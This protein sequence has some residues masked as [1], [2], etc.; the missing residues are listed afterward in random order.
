MNKLLFSIERKGRK[1]GVSSA[2]DIM[3]KVLKWFVIVYIGFLFFGLG[4]GLNPMVEEMFPG[5]NIVAVVSRYIIFYFSAEL[6]FRFFLQKLPHGNIRPLLIQNITRSKIVK[7]FLTSS[8][9]S[10]F[11]F[12]QLIFFVTFSVASIFFLKGNYEVIA[13][14]FSMYAICLGLHYVF[15]LMESYNTVFY[16]VIVVIG[17]LGVVQYY[18]LYDLGVYLEPIFY[19]P[20]KNPAALVL[21][22]AFPLV[23]AFFAYRYY[24]DRLY[25]ENIDVKETKGAE[26]QDFNWLNRFG[27]YAIFLKNDVRLL[28]RNKRAKSTI[29]VGGL[30]LFY[31]LLLIN[32][33]ETTSDSMFL[34]VVIGYIVSGGFMSMFGQFVPSWDSAHYNLL[35]SLNINYK[36]YLTA[37]WLLMSIVIILSTVLGAFYLYWSVQLYLMIIAMAIFNIGVNSLIVLY[38]GCFIR[39]PIDL[40]ANKNIFGDK[41]A[42]NAKVLLLSI[43]QFLVPIVLYALGSIH[44]TM[45]GLILIA[46]AGV[47]GM[48]FRGY[49][50]KKI[51][52]VYES[53]KYKLIDAFQKK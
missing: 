8:F 3:V 2:T 51:A 4:M 31:G 15:I 7:Y 37:K 34:S 19:L 53:D 26:T 27:F 20:Y 24:L 12:L 29:M 1:R 25:I 46:G 48:F 40:S 9:I 49:A 52:K 45:T 33:G 35:M 16:A 6:S 14:S 11:N 42:F 21:Y 39:S 30:F 32:M 38:T 18:Q 17:A 44:S 22:F 13:W 23:T 50:F 47:I 43:P 28:L 36:E 41:K 10:P 5:E